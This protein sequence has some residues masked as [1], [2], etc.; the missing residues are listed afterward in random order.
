MRGVRVGNVD[1]RSMKTVPTMVQGVGQRLPVV[2]MQDG[3]ED[4]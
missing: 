2:M 4:A 3:P 1:M